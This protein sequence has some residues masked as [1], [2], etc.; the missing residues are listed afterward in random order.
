MSVFCID[1]EHAKDMFQICK[2]LQGLMRKNMFFAPKNACFPPYF[3]GKWRNPKFRVQG[4]SAS[5]KFKSCQDF[6]ALKLIY[7]QNDALLLFI[8]I[9]L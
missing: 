6:F 9:N 3:R 8:Y 5:L 2:W 1:F 7:H 4:W